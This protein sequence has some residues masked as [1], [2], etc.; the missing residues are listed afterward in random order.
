MGPSGGACAD[1]RATDAV[2]ALSIGAAVAGKAV[3]AVLVVGALRETDDVIVRGRVVGAAAKARVVVE[4]LRARRAVVG[5][6]TSARKARRIAVIACRH[7]AD[8][9]EVCGGWAGG[10][11]GTVVE[12][13][14]A[15]ARGAVCAGLRARRAVGRTVLAGVGRALDVLV[16]VA[17]A[18]CVRACEGGARG[19][20]GAHVGARSR[21]RQAGVIAAFTG[22]GGG[23]CKRTRG[24]GGRA[25]ARV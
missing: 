25:I 16:G 21:A 2:V 22:V 17:G 6:G 4:K 11:A 19:A 10:L 20:A 18:A 9:L 13:L 15:G 23:V 24:A 3:A 12:D 7:V 8:V 14:A 1:T 5:A